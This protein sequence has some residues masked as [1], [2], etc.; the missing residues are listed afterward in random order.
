MVHEEPDTD[1]EALAPSARSAAV[2]AP[3]VKA[4][5]PSMP[6][7]E[8]RFVETIVEKAPEKEKKP[9]LFNRLFS[10]LFGPEE[11]S[12]QPAG[13]AGEQPRSQRV[14]PSREPA[15]DRPARSG[16]ARGGQSQGRRRSGNQSRQAAGRPPRRDHTPREDRPQQSTPEQH[17]IPA[18][19]E[20]TGIQSVTGQESERPERN[21]GRGSSRRGRRGGRNRPSGQRRGNDRPPE[22]MTDE[23]KADTAQG[24]GDSPIA[25]GQNPP[26]TSASTAAGE[27][28]GSAPEQARKPDAASDGGASQP[29]RNSGQS[30]V[31][32]PMENTSPPA[33]TPLPAQERKSPGETTASACPVEKV[34]VKID[35]ASS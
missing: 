30:A 26:S 33:V 20:S 4:V 23:S 28:H 9:G 22:R 12:E 27:Q 14:Q 6:A 34:E 10:S 1:L 3:A 17:E 13:Q 18:P 25:G 35:K 11:P 32:K 5:A 15:R 21:Q 16:A 31:H 8:H 7:P 29:F 19:S 24:G 2:E